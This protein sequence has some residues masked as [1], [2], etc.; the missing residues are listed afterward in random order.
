M[1][2]G[3]LSIF[4]NLNFISIDLSILAIDNDFELGNDIL[5]FTGKND[6][7]QLNIF[8][9]DMTNKSLPSCKLRMKN[10]YD[11][12]TNFSETFKKGDSFAS[13]K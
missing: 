7:L 10:N 3:K 4:S 2:D 13:F 1:D 5:I 11:H 12:I 6:K 8:K 9:L